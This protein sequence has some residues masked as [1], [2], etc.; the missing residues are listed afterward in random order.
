MES[1]SKIK[2]VAPEAKFVHWSIHHEAL[3]LKKNECDIEDS[4][5]WMW[6]SD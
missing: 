2:E 4:A 1:F 6:Q 5:K 3:G